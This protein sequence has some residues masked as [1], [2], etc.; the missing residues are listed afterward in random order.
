MADHIP[1]IIVGN[2]IDAYR[3]NLFDDYLTESEKEEILSE[4]LAHFR[5]NFEVTLG[6]LF[7]HQKE[8]T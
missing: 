7:Q 5:S 4:Q 2:K 8:K 3:E 6:Y 1:T